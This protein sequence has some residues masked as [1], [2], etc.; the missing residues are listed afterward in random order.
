M[1]HAGREISG[2]VLRKML[3]TFFRRGAPCDG[4]AAQSVGSGIGLE[5]MHLCHSVY[6]GDNS[7][8][9]ARKRRK[10]F[11]FALSKRDIYRK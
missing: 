9:A 7:L 4:W 2:E 10:N 11:L 1:I 8:V 5:K 3:R 6:G